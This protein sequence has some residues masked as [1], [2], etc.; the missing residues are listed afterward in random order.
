MGGTGIPT[1]TVTFLFTDVEKST[2]MW[3]NHPAEMQAAL[4]RHDGIVRDCIER[5][6]GYVFSLAGDQF[7]AAFHQVPHAL[8][9]A[10]EAQEQ[11]GAENWPEHTPIRVRIGIH[12][13]VADERDGD[14]FG[15]VL[16][17][18]A[19]IVSAA[20]G[21][22]TLLSGAA[23]A[24][25]PGLDLTD[26]GEHRL[27]DLAEAQ[28]LWQAGA[29]T[30]PTLRTMQVLRHNLPVER[31]PLVGRTDDVNDISTRVLDNRLITLLGIGGTGKTR[32]ALAVAAE[33]A[34]RFQD[35][36]WF[37]DLVPSTDVTSVVERAISE[38]S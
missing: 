36:T 15:P 13:G 5:N 16:N 38:L 33:I 17:R 30:Y 29:D 27:K 20:H 25:A 10:S 6:A 26:L 28:H 2:R 23:A 12:I 8:A 1:G 9:A 3:Q 18:T 11:I 34:D 24:L 35:G 4:G 19:R 31:T 37:I 32:L 7:V 22:Q 21:G 14:Y